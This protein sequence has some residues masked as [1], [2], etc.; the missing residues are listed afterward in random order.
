MSDTPALSVVIPHFNHPDALA[1][2]L[3][4][5]C[6]QTGA[7][8]AEI[9]VVDN[10]STARPDAVVAGF[11]GVRLIDEATPGPG[12]ARSAGAH[13]ARAPL[14]AFIDA[15]CIADPDWLATIAAYMDAHPGTAVIGG[16]VRIAFADPARPTGIEAYEAIWGYRQRLYVERDHYTATL[17]MAVRA[18]VF[19]AVG[20]FAGIEIAEDV[21]WGRRATAAGHRIDFVAAMKIA[22]PARES[23]SELARKWDRHIGHDFAEKPRPLAWAARAAAVAVSPLAEVPKVLASDRITGAGARLRAGLT[24]VRVRLFRARR[25]AE[26]LLR[27]PGHGAADAWRE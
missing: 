26:W 14:L 11:P 8:D 16:D 25:M 20:D 15:D 2:C 27:R 21:D 18:D 9:I 3:T 7:P 12:P 22:T 13:A 19:A 10:A 23:F 1:R 24:L 17:N 4:A 5:L 6:A